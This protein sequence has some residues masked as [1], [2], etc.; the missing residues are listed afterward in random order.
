MKIFDF[1][2]KESTESYKKIIF[3]ALVS[4][5][6]NG[7]LLALINHAAD[8]VS[9][10]T[11]ISQY[12]IIYLIAFLLFMY[13][14]WFAY[15]QAI[16]AI[17]DSVSNLRIRL[18]DK[19]LYVELS[20]V[21]N[22][23]HSHLYN[24]LTQDSSLMSQA[25]PQ[26]TAAGQTAILIIFSVFYLAMISPIS[27]FITI[28]AIISGIFLYLSSTKVVQKLLHQVIDQEGKYL[29]S[30]LQ[31]INGFKEIKINKA[32][33][34]D[35]FSQL[36]KN[37]L[38]TKAIKILVGHDEMKL[39]GFGKNACYAILPL[40]VFIVPLF[41]QEHA[42]DVYKVSSTMLFISGPIT[43]LI[44]SMPLINRVNVILDNLYALEKEIDQVSNQSIEAEEFSLSK[45]ESIKLCDIYFSFPKKKNASSFSI[46]PLNISI[47]KGEL[48]F[49]IGG[50]G[51]GK[52]TFLKILT[53]LYTPETGVIYFNAEEEIY[54]NNQQSY[55]ELFSIIFTDF[56]LFDQFYGIKNLNEEKVNYWLKKMQMQ[57][58]TRYKNGRFSNM[59]LSTGQRKRLAF[60]SAMLEDKPILIIDEFAADQDPEFRQYFYEQLLKELKEQGKTIIAVTHD[61]HYF[62]VAD[63]VL[64]MDAGNLTKF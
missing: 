42:A 6:A 10:K 24:R 64:K 25:I 8:E 35:I 19:L 23:G 45:F 28:I 31:I 38:E 16:K 9:N 22:I 20:F 3:M 46:G 40:L 62:H 13:T 39:W 14:Q 58:K 59:D 56:H 48:L 27:F 4:G 5:F 54:D 51:S 49:I 55:R 43:L 21:E 47:T 36:K 7:L 37:S 18:A 15:G 30:L 33:R 1:I 2:K 41:Y 61:D 52:S 44:S 63:R 53:R 26:L 29:D 32:K 57:H 11:V 34:D 50:N 60:I 12:F 17:E